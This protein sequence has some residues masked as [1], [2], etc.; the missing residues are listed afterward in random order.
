MFKL[1]LKLILFKHSDVQLFIIKLTFL[2]EE[3]KDHFYAK[4]HDPK[5][6]GC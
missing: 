2:V 1:L 5:T 6:H 4:K 3:L